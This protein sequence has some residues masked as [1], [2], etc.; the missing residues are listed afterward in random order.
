MNITV[1]GEEIDPRMIEQ[2]TERLRSH[3]EQYAQANNSK[4]SDEQLTEWS[5]ENLIERALLQQEAKKTDIKIEE[6][7]AKLTKDVEPPS[8][9]EITSFYDSNKKFFST[10]E[11]IRAAHIVKHV[12]NPEEKTDAYVAISNIQERIK[13]GETFEQL[14]SE[15]SDCPE[16]AGDLG[17]FPRGQMVQEFE[18]VVFKMK[19]GEVSDAFLSPFGYHIVKLNDRKEAGVAPFEEVKP[20]ISAKMTR[21][22]QNSIMESFVDGLKSKADIARNQSDPE[23]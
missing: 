12:N 16:N 1:N 22:R 2:E 7:V 5:T 6:L 10:P 18:D 3:Y 8:D 11:Q 21:D 13:N 19:V 17:Y 15:N 20:H 9:E 23:Q 4:P 14:A